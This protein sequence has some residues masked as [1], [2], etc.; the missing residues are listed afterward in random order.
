MRL[1]T[2][3]KG[4]FQIQAED[5]GHLLDVEPGLVPELMRTGQIT[6]RSETG[7]GE[8]QGRF[9]L[10]F[11][12]GAVTLRLIVSTDGEILQQSRIRQAWDR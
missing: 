11:R 12:Y 8:D 9:R 1:E 2:L 5:L 4:G 6:S 10:T 3:P 7:Q